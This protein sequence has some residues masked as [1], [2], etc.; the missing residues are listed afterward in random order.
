M[1]Y[2]PISLETMDFVKHSWK[3]VCNFLSQ[4]DTYTSCI[5]LVDLNF[6]GAASITKEAFERINSYGLL[7]T[8]LGM[9]IVMTILG[10]DHIYLYGII[11]IFSFS[12]IHQR[13]V[14]RTLT[15]SLDLKPPIDNICTNCNNKSVQKQVTDGEKVC[16]CIC[17]DCSVPLIECFI[18]NKKS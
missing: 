1:K 7:L 8:I 14:Y 17:E 12:A 10:L 15:L 13:Q 2:I 4:F 3:S 18:C 9:P 11:S 16:I 5:F 6:N